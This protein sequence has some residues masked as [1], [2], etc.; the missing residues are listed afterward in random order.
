[1]WEIIDS[2]IQIDY[3]YL[4]RHIAYCILQNVINFKSTS[5]QSSWE[6]DALLA[7]GQFYSDSSL[8]G[9]HT[10]VAKLHAPNIT[11]S[12]IKAQAQQ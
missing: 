5:L 4:D 2:F 7:L 11:R 6:I 12:V 1:M 10:I 8:L 3:G 9:L